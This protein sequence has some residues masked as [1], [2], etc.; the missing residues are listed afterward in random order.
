MNIFYVIKLI[1]TRNGNRGY[2]I[3]T[4]D[5]IELSVGNLDMNITQ[6]ETEKQAEKFIRERKL[7]RGG[8]TAHIRSNQ[9]LLEDEKGNPNLRPADGDI[10]FIENA[11]GEKL[12]Y[13]SKDK[14]YFYKKG[15]AGYPCWYT[16]EQITSFIEAYKLDDAIIKKH[17]KKEAVKDYFLIS[18]S[19]NPNEFLHPYPLQTSKDYVFKEGY[20]GAAGFY[21]KEALEISKGCT[22][23]GKIVPMNGL[24]KN[25]I[26]E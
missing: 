12:F 6:F 9:E 18:N 19:E 4:K 7:Q 26:K 2:V 13:D 14:G 22:P 24:T 25:I 20:V 23:I 5:G 3:D 15:E 16:M 1:N 17:V 11:D 21:E 10:F 8:M